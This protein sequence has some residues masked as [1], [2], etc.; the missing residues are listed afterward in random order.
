MLFRKN[1]KVT[2]RLEN[3]ELKGELIIP[4][5]AQSVV[6][7][8]HGS[9]SNY[10]STRN[11]IVAKNLHQKNIGTLLINLLTEK[12][13][14]QYRNRFDIELLTKRLIRIVDWVEDEENGKSLSIGLYGS[15][16]GAAAA[17]RAAAQLPMI[18][19]VVS[20]GGRPDLAVDKLE[21]VE[22]PVLL[23]VGGLDYDVLKMNELAYQKLKCEKRIEILQGATHLFEE[24]GMIHKV[25]QLTSAWFENYLQPVIA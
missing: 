6:I 11:Q 3:A 15:S 21:E 20:R 12:E 2:I 24:H 4:L 7:F 22:S 14:L 19:A 17:I 25:A 13:D 16:T 1:N 18:G 23:I 10:L 8:A 5:K 9:G